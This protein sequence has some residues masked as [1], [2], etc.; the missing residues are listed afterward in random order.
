MG[1]LAFLTLTLAG[2]AVTGRLRVH[3]TAFDSDSSFI[4]VKFHKAWQ[5]SVINQYWMVEGV[6]RHD[7]CRKAGE[8]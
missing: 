8:G 7:L 4:Q 1:A 5:D 3:T 2:A 6:Q